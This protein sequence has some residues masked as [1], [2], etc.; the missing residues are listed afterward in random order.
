MKAMKTVMRAM[1][2]TKEMT[3][4]VP[5]K[6]SS[7]LICS[8]E[9]TFSCSCTTSLL[10]NKELLRGPP[11]MVT[12]PLQRLCCQ[13][14]RPRMPGRGKPNVNLVLL[15]GQLGGSAGTDLL[16][17]RAALGANVPGRPG[18]LASLPMIKS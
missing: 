3:V 17:G 13:K 12:R 15:C 8:S 5:M 1:T 4:M 7:C 6:M 14:P 16:W 11:S 2:R 18:S 9:I 10:A